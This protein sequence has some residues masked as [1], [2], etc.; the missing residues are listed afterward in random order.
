MLDY[1]H[2]ISI[3]QWWKLPAHLSVSTVP[4]SVEDEKHEWVGRAQAQLSD[5]GLIHAP[6]TEWDMQGN[7]GPPGASLLLLSQSV[8]II[9][10]VIR[11]MKLN[12]KKSAQ[13]RESIWQIYLCMWKCYSLNPSFI[14]FKNN[15]NN[16]KRN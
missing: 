6:L 4:G 12:V 5:L 13:H 3:H 2:I 15:N 16:K 9:L 8:E 11:K 10:W 14:F 7:P 1:F